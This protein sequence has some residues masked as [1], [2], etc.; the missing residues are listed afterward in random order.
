MITNNKL[1]GTVSP[2]SGVPHV[3]NEDKSSVLFG[4]LFKLKS[5]NEVYKTLVNEVNYVLNR[6]R[7]DVPSNV[8]KSEAVDIPHADG[9][10]SAFDLEV[11]ELTRCNS[12]LNTALSE[13][14]NF[15]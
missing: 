2:Y 13:L 7:G 1:T 10:C 11:A 14:K 3:S 5:E 8:S 6:I 15:I 9:F 4:L 12:S